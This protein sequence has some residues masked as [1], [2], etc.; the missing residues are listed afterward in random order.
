[1]N[2]KDT[3]IPPHGTEEDRLRA[4]AVFIRHARVMGLPARELMTDERI[5]EVFDEKW[6]P[7]AG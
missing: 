2:Q 1:M 7:M 6:P 3:P 5:G 4:R